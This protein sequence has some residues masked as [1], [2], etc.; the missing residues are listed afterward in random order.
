MIDSRLQA[1][2]RSSQSAPS[3]K[4]NDNTYE[5][6]QEAIDAAAEKKVKAA[7]ALVKAAEA[8]EEVL[9][10][11]IAKL[12]QQ[13]MMA[14]AEDEGKTKAIHSKYQKDH[15]AMASQHTSEM[16]KLNAVLNT[17]QQELQQERRDGAIAKA[18][19]ASMDRMCKQMESQMKVAK[20]VQ[21]PDV[22]VILPPAA[23]MKPVTMKVSQRD[24]NG[25]IAAVT[26]TQS[27]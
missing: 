25:K 20:P 6:I 21:V 16:Q 24:S 27:T 19:C 15:A 13:L 7:E 18:D 10:K 26:I 22:Q 4:V 1:L 8:R 11:E 2:I 12:T 9:E 17:V 5:A 14:K 3:T 23:P